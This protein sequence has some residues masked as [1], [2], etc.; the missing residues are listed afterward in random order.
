MSFSVRLSSDLV[1]IEAG[2]TV[3]LA[4]EVSNKGEAEDRFELE[5]EGIDPEWT[6]VPVP[7]FTVGGGEAQSEKVFFKPPR[8]SES[9]AGNYPFVVKVRSLISG[10]S[11]SVQGIAQIKPYHY[12][13]MEVSP[14]KG[15]FSPWRRHNDFGITI[16]N[17][18]NTEHT[19]QL[20]GNDPD[21]LCTFEFEHEQV[22]IGPGAQREVE[23]VVTPESSPLMSSSRLHG[24]SLAGRSLETPSV[25]SSTQAQLEQHALMTPG[26]MAVMTILA[27][28]IALWVYLLPKPPTVQASLDKQTVTLGDPVTVSWTSS[29]ATGVSVTANEKLLVGAPE[30]S[31]SR[32]FRPEQAGMITFR[33]KAI[34]DNKESP[35]AQLVL[36]VVPPNVAPLPKV[37]LTASKKEVEPNEP[38]LLTYSFSGNVEK[39]VL[40]PLGETLDLNTRERE[41]IRTTPGKVTYTIVA[42]NKDGKTASKSVEVNVVDKPD[43]SIT[44]FTATPKEV[45]LDDGRVTLNWALRDAAKA[46][47]TDGEQTVSLEVPAGSLE[48]T[49]TRN[50]TFT[51]IAYDSQGRSV[52]Q[53]RRVAV[54][55]PPST[56]GDT[57]GGTTPIT[58]GGG[59]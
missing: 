41:I 10:E 11:R 39:A 34:R 36:E 52:K 35:E 18:G 3:P 27:L 21:D 59:L 7:M 53:T 48:L 6:A 55:P 56:T 4:V 14:K 22:T 45:S 43:V 46:E 12:L 33:V 13:T 9:S 47:L 29:N 50:R 58:T 1:Q 28:I 40:S 24:F 5:I 20:Y 38:F 8:T 32:T 49:I 54:I 31:G 15:F 37:T 17:L 57:T 51:L 23:V 42:T 2:A 26:A 16:V 25:V 44:S 30:P 19:L